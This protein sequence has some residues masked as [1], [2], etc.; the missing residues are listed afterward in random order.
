MTL[1]VQ[2][3]YQLTEQ[4]R[5][6]VQKTIAYEQSSLAAN[7]RRTYSVMWSKFQSWCDE[8]RLQPL[9]ASAETISLYLSSLGGLA[10][11][12]TID[13]I[14][15]AIEKAHAQ[16]GVA[17]SGNQDLYRRVRKGIRR[18]HKEKQALK[19]AK[20]LSLIELSIIC[21]QLGTS[22]RDV[23]DKAIITIAFFGALRRS[24]VV[25]LD[26]DHVEIND[27]GAVLHLLQTK[28]SDEVVHLYL[29]KTKDP[30]ICPIKA[31]QSWIT[32]SGI[33]Q[34]A[35]FRSLIKGG[36][37]SEQRLTG[38]AVATIMKQRFGQ[39]YSGHSLRRGL[40]TAEAEKGTPLH[41]IQ[42]HSRHKTA[43][44]VMRYIEK[45]EGFETSSAVLLGV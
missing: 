35:L 12:S 45:V 2:P 10:S 29:S 28:T 37:V 23:R 17:I 3:N 24:E 40:V 1:I 38:H 34:G 26:I 44:I 42:Q 8:N 18:E 43:D 25:G 19:Q 7:T 13:C 22:I 31:L 33:T 20:A 32:A 39:E 21:R 16:K 41:K 4:Q 30:C 5:D 6:L 15:A 27:K 36:S 14:I 11:F 9:P